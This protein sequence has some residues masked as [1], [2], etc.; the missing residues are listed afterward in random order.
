MSYFGL[1]SDLVFVEYTHQ[2]WKSVAV[3]WPYNIFRFWLAGIY[4]KRKVKGQLIPSVF[5]KNNALSCVSRVFH[6]CLVTVPLRNV[7]LC[8]L[9]SSLEI[10]ITN[11]AHVFDIVFP[12]KFCLSFGTARNVSAV[13][14]LL[15]IYLIFSFGSLPRFYSFKFLCLPITLASNLLTT[16]QLTV[17]T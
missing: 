11:Y 12:C 9:R 3:S 7:K 16:V 1:F 4:E 15:I 5:T 10:V 17:K 2:L 6:A 14:A 13:F 8:S